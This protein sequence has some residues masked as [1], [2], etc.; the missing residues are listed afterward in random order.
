MQRSMIQG[1]FWGILV[2][3]A[4]TTAAQASD[5][6]GT[7]AQVEGDVKIFSHPGKKVQGPPP[8]ALYEGEYY[9]VRDAKS[10]DK[11]E[12]GNIVRTTPGAKARVIYD[13]GDQLTVSGGSAYRVKWAGEGAKGK[14]DLNLMYGKVRAMVAKGGP[15][16]QLTVR[17]RSATMGVRGTDFFVADGGTGPNAGTEISVIRG[18]VAV[19]AP[20]AKPKDK[21]VPVKAGTTAEIPA[22]AA[23]AEE[24][25]S[26]EGKAKTEEKKSEDVQAPA[27][28]PAPV[29][30][31]RP[32]T[33]QDLSAIQKSSEVKAAISEEVK[34]DE[35]LAKKIEELEK[36]AVEATLT[37]IKKEDPKL[38]AQLQER[39]VS[40]ALEIQ[41]Q[42]VEAVKKEAPVAPARTKPS[43]A[44]LENLESG[45][46]EQYFKAVE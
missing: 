6:V 13:N 15:R 7:L 16:S 43:R 5:Q 33:Q 14:P 27:E 40:N 34:K 1:R 38:F 36:K 24:N 18:E 31:V 21:P 22:P 23:L 17:T 28:I 42:A 41:T 26:A 45:V 8:H 44:E 3:A 11:V 4:M 9:S 32:T 37:D 35:K 46:Y 29:I 12:N 20:N 30:A 2:L 10:G 19:K 25:K 39:K